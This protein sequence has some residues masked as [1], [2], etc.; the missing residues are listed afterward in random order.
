MAKT[1]REEW[2]ARV[3]RWRASGLT[4]EQFATGE[5]LKAGT[6]DWWSSRLQRDRCDPVGFVEVTLPPTS[7]SGRIEI[8]VRNDVRIEVSGAFD[9]EVLR[10]VVAALETR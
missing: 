9:A 3:R 8:V 5:G 2:T 10:R 6:L 1:A 7:P 4:A